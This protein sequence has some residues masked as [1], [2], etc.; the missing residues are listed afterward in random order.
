MPPS[1][2][3]LG[4][5]AVAIPAGAHAFA[6]RPRLLVAALVA[7]AAAVAVAQALAELSRA[8]AGVVGDAQLGAALIASALATAFVA[9]VEPRRR[10]DTTRRRN[11]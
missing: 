8:S 6:G 2:V 1:L 10:R 7:S 5:V 3:L 11:T 4:L 9:L